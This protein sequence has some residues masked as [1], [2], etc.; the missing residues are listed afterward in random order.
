[1]KNAFA[2]CQKC[3]HFAWLTLTL[4]KS[5]R[6]AVPPGHPILQLSQ[7]D[8]GVGRLARNFH[9]MCLPKVLKGKRRL[10]IGK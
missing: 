7:K 4:G 5:V 8:G 2:V 3:R 9:L 10:S 1:M 6:K